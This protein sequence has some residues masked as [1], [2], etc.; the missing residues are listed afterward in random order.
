MSEPKRSSGREPD[1]QSLI[2]QY[3]AQ[4]G[5]VTQCPPGP[6]DTLVYKRSFT[7]PKRKPEATARS[8]PAELDAGERDPGPAPNEPDDLLL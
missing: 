4:G 7:T 3:L 6:S 8:M 2:E 1:L 5:P